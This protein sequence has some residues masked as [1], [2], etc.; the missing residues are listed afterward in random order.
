MPFGW[1]FGRLFIRNEQRVWVPLGAV[2]SG[3]EVLKTLVKRHE[4]DSAA[5]VWIIVRWHRRI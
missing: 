5:H 2:E 3:L 4:T 1:L